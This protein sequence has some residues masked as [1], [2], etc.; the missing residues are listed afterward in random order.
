[1]EKKPTE[2]DM[3]YLDKWTRRSAITHGISDERLIEICNAERDG[4]CIVLLK[5]PQ[6][7]LY[8]GEE[9]YI[10]DEGEVYEDFVQE[11]ILG[12][13]AN[14]RNKV[15][16]LYNTGDLY[17]FYECAWGKTVFPTRKEAEAA[18]NGGKNGN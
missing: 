6:N 17:A 2:R 14:D 8:S 3:E 10:V 15:G 12:E 5:K 18:I 9:I 16:V 7:N 11:I 4:R 1:M 13:S